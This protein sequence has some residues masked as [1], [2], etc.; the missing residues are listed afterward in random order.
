MSAVGYVPIYDIDQFRSAVDGGNG[1][2]SCAGS[3]FVPY[4][5]FDYSC[6]RRFTFVVYRTLF[7][8]FQ[9]SVQQVGTAE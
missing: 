9:K 2:L 8:D 7:Y 4:E 6:N 5:S 1:H 3:L